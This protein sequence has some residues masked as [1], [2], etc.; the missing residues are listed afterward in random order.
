MQ[1]LC[2]VVRR[3][4]KGK[5]TTYGIIAKKI[6]INPRAVAASLRKN[7]DRSIPCHRVVYSDGKIGGYNRGI[8]NKIALLKKE[9]IKIKNGKII[10]FEKVLFNY[11]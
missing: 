8:K 1:D 7:F 5:V 2:S 11:F 6:G 3:V 4:P 9:G 10:E